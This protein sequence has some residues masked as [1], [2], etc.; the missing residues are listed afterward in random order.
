MDSM[1][2]R[3]SHGRAALLGTR[4]TAPPPVPVVKA[5]RGKL[6]EVHNVSWEKG[7]RYYTRSHKRGGKIIREYVGN[8]IEAELL[9]K[10]DARNAKSERPN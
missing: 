1:G 3:V 2:A 8:S 5:K 4:L 6:Q 10:I 9:A 7:G